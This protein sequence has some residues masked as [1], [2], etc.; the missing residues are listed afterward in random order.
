MPS[1]DCKSG[2]VV[3]DSGRRPI[4]RCLVTCSRAVSTECAVALPCIVHY[5]RA[6]PA[7]GNPPGLAWDPPSPDAHAGCSPTPNPCCVV[8]EEPPDTAVYARGLDALSPSLLRIPL[9]PTCPG[10]NVERW[11]CLCCPA[12]TCCPRAPGRWRTPYLHLR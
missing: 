1:R 2:C 9:A 3:L 4:I 5:A 12:A 11:M 10:P 6:A 8:P 7:N